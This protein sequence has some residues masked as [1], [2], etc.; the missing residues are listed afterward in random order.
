MGFIKI[1]E[2]DLKKGLI[3]EPAW[4]R[5]RIDNMEQRTSSK[6][7][8]QNHFPS[9]KILFNADTGETKYAGVETPKGW[10]FNEGAPAFTIPFLVATGTD[11][12]ELMKAIKEAGENGMRLDMDSAVGKDLDIFIENG[13]YEGRSQNKINH[14]YRRP[15]AR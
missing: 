9:G 3:V 6:G 13:V 8:S 4:Y 7:T 11:E 14:K 1:T 15:V 12:A 5:V 10:C 2:D